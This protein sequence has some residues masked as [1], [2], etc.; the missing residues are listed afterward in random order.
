M[1]WRQVDPMSERH[2]F[3]TDARRRIASFA[4]LCTHYGISRKTGYKWLGRAEAQGSAHLA[5]HSRRPHTCPHATPERFVTRLLQ[6]RTPPPPPPPPPPR[7]PPAL[8]PPPRGAPPA[9]SALGAAQAAEGAAPA[10]STRGA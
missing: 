10:R 6:T 7:P 3:I 2:R 1:P 4:E 8:A 9:A 5:E